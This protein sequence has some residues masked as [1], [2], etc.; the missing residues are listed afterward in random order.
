MRFLFRLVGVLVVVAVAWVG[1]WLIGAR[2][3]EEALAAWL[4][5][6]AEAGWQADYATLD[7]TGF[8]DRFDRR[9]EDLVLTNPEQGWS[10][11]APWIASSSATF[12]INAFTVAVAPS[13]TFA[14]PGERIAVETAANRLELAVEP[15][16][17]MPLDRARI[18]ISDLALETA[19][20]DA[21]A[22]AFEA[23]VAERAADSGPENAYDFAL[24][25]GDV[26]LP[27][28]LLQVLDPTGGLAPRLERIELDGHAALDHTLD[29]DFVEAGELSARTVVLRRA[30]FRWG[31]MALAARGR[32]D[33]DD[34][35]LAEGEV[36][37]TLEN[38]R[39]MLRLAEES[40][41][42]RRELARGIEGALG[43]ASLFGSDRDALDVTLA[44]EDGR[45]W[46]GPVPVGDA[47][48]I[49]LPPRARS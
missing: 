7:V 31:E 47:P 29:R 44:F 41:A 4:A 5:G 1:W 16:P 25:A 39:R 35:G 10:L 22:A 3:Q 13:F 45:I 2:A 26:V 32:I 37:L 14:V 34:E 30:V 24:E 36:A 42:I 46:L 38:W 28:P 18:T 43:L 9:V 23:S 6:R 8:P 27:R 12:G 40:G 21:G 48:R 17:S 11:R 49:S 33:A 19:G 15:L 20:W